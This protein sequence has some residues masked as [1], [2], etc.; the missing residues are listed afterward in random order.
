MLEI[1]ADAVNGSDSNS[2]TSVGAP[3]K[4]LTKAESLL[5]DVQNILWLV[6]SGVYTD[7]LN[8]NHHQSV[9]VKT[10]GKGKAVIK[11]GD[12]AL[13]GVGCRNSAVL[14]L[15][16]IWV[17]PGATGQHL[18]N[19][20]QNVCFDL[21]NC[22]LGESGVA[23]GALIYAEDYAKVIFSGKDNNVRGSGQSFVSLNNACLNI[24]AWV[25]MPT[26]GLAFS[27]GFYN[28][29]INSIFRLQETIHAGRGGNVNTNAR[30]YILSHGS[31]MLLPSAYSIPGTGV[32]SPI[33]D[34][35]S[36]AV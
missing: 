31:K 11:A 29:T 15:T 12:G 25:N 14:T 33:V 16:N 26:A 10:Y 1:W 22:D 32:Q 9:H 17:K 27:N 36:Y 6:P 30:P 3:V 19:V 24:N 7:A 23:A 2:G 18:C 13:F 35:H 20:G 28:G 21:V 5:T 4:T 34:G 8:V